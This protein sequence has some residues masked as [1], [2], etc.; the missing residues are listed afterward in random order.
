M[1]RRFIGAAAA[2]LAAALALPASA[3]VTL[4]P[5]QARLDV[6]S[7]VTPEV[8]QAAVATAG[9]YTVSPA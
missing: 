9:D 8:A 6:P 5:P 1:S 7:A 3:H 4:D 2:C